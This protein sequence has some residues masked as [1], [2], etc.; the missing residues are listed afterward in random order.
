MTVCIPKNFL[1]LCMC[2]LFQIPFS[3]FF[4]S[5]KGRIQDV[6]KKLHLDR[7]EYLSITLADGNPGPF[8]LE[9]DYIALL[10]D[11]GHFEE[12]AYE[13]YGTSGSCLM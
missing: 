10:Q 2:F 11:E 13:N 8:E 7:V 1:M 3:K 4:L 6:Q 5:S 9:L 12:F